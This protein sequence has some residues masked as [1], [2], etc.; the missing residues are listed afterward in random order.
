M[1]TT[2]KKPRSRLQKLTTE[3]NC[4]LRTI[5]CMRAQLWALQFFAQPALLDRLRTLFLTIETQIRAQEVKDIT[6]E[7]RW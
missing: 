1:Q 4:A 5:A 7:P 2:A 6:R 3:K